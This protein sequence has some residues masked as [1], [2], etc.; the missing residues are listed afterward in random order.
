MKPWHKALMARRAS[1][2]LKGAVLRYQQWLERQV[3]DADHE[4][5]FWL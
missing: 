1:R 3:R 5:L 2:L 4:P